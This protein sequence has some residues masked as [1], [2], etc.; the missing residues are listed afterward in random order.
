MKLTP[1]FIACAALGLWAC[2]SSA[3]PAGVCESGE[4]YVDCLAGTAEGCPNGT[5]VYQCE[6]GKWAM[7]E[8]NDG[9]AGSGDVAVPFDVN[10][11]A[12]K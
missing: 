12:K 4:N 8:Q 1:V 10:R 2:N 7:V 9:M 6:N 11:D 3:P 5:H